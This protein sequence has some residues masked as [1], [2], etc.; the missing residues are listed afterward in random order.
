MLPTY[1]GYWLDRVE[2]VMIFKFSVSCKLWSVVMDFFLGWYLRVG[3]VQ[4]GCVA[5]DVCGIVVRC[6]WWSL[7]MWDHGCVFARTLVEIVRL[8][9]IL[10]NWD[11]LHS[12][13]F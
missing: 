9:P 6:A 3:V 1:L 13:R 2:I 10:S 11:V 12:P 5:E 7:G 4:V 8:D